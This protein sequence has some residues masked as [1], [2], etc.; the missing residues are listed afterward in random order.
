MTAY[1]VASQ[2]VVGF[3]RIMRVRDILDVLRDCK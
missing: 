3:R 2:P 1:D